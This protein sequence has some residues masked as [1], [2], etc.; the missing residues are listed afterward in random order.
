MKER[1]PCLAPAWLQ[2]TRSVSDEAI[3]DTEGVWKPWGVLGLVSA[4]KVCIARSRGLSRSVRRGWQMSPDAYHADLWG[5]CCPQRREKSTSLKPA[6]PDKPYERKT[7]QA[8]DFLS[9]AWS[10]SMSNTD[11]DMINMNSQSAVCMLA[12]GRADVTLAF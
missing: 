9:E 10:S 5:I 6:Q 12:G 3:R 2:V 7:T 11:T 8:V 4:R 1:G